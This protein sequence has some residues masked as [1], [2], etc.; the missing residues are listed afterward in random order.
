MDA[1]LER[2]WRSFAKSVD[3]LLEEHRGQY[4]LWRDDTA[5]EFFDTYERALASGLRR[6]GLDETFL[7]AEVEAPNAS[8]P[9]AWQ[10]GVMFDGHGEPSS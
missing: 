10:A 8:L 9:V 4:V 3:R 2:E 6:F 1:T 5:V 7:V